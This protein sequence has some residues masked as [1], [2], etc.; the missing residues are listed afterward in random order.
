VMGVIE[1]GEIIVL[2]GRLSSRLVG[3]CYDNYC[4]WCASR[5]WL[6]ERAMEV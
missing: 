4:L 5:N 6:G 3:L 1:T 2:L